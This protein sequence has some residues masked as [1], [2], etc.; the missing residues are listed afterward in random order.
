MKKYRI[1][2]LLFMMIFNILLTQAVCQMQDE[3]ERFISLS[4]GKYHFTTTSLLGF[5]YRDYPVDYSVSLC[6]PISRH[7]SL[8]GRYTYIKMEGDRRYYD[9][10]RPDHGWKG[11]ALLTAGLINA[12]V[13]VH[14]DLPASFTGG[15]DCGPSF[16]LGSE[17]IEEAGYYVPG[18]NPDARWWLGYSY[19][20]FGLFGGLFLAHGVPG[21]PCSISAEVDCNYLASTNTI[22]LSEY[23]GVNFLVG[24][25]YHF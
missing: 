19:T 15:I 17:K 10:R 18:N 24:L 9:D 7:I 2:N 4:V 6:A 3:N 23:T 12:G 20:V 16:S 11:P 25:D 8:F 22:F 13:R 1:G 14:A 5:T 21:T